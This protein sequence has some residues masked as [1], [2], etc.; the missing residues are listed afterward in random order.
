MLLVSDDETFHHDMNIDDQLGERIDIPTV[1]LKKSDG[2][3]IIDYLKKNELTKVTMSIKFVSVSENGKIVLKLFM[4][5][6]D[7]KALEFFKEF[8][9]YYEKMCKIDIINNFRAS[10]AI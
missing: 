9:G 5:S 6:D 8:R 2:Q 1:I 3:A 4:R 7:V 10:Y